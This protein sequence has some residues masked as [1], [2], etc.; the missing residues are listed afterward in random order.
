MNRNLEYNSPQFIL[1]LLAGKSAHAVPDRLNKQMESERKKV[2]GCWLL[3]KI[4]L[5]I[6]VTFWPLKLMCARNKR[7]F[8]T[9]V[10][11]T[12]WGNVKV[13]LKRKAMHHWRYYVSNFCQQAFAQFYWLVPICHH[14]IC[15]KLR[16]LRVSRSR[17]SSPPVICR[18][19]ATLKAVLWVASC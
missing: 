9:S 1:R 3:I 2:S 13:T 19:W 7:Y 10:W 8:L 15:R 4:T 5:H 18:L 17:T 16:D 11:S 12:I 6:L 14:L